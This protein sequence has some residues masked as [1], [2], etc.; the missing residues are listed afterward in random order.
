[1]HERNPCVKYIFSEFEAN[2]FPQDSL[3]LQPVKSK[4]A[5]Y[6]SRISPI[7]PPINYWKYYVPCAILK[8]PL[9]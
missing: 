4:K 8:V 1:M 2:V 7:M 9:I 6:Q 5:T 3:S